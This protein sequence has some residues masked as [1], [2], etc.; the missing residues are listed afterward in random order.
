MRRQLAAALGYDPLGPARPQG[1]RAAQEAP[2]ES[3]VLEDAELMALLEL[4][5]PLIAVP[6]RRALAVV[7]ET[8]A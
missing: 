2:P 5:D 7:L 3:P 4:S 1:R 8:L 6:L